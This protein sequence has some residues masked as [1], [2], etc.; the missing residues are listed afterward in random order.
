LNPINT[1][2]NL[3]T[4]IKGAEFFDPVVNLRLDQA[5]G[6]VGV[7]AAAHDASGGY[8]LTAEGSGHPSDKWGWAVSPAFLWNN[9]FGLQGDAI[10]AQGVYSKGAAGY[11]TPTFGPTAVFGSGQ[12]VALGW[13]AEG[14]FNANNSVELTTV[15]S[16]NSAYEHRWNPQWRTS[17]YGG[18]F[19]VEY[20][21]TAK[22]LI[23]TGLARG[24]A[25]TG[26]VTINN[27]N[28]DPNFS[29]S[30][31]GTR[32]LWNP[33]P[34]LD[35]G[36]DLTWWHLNTAFRDQT[37]TLGPIGAKPAGSYTLKDQDAL[38]A[39]FRVQRNFLY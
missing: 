20:N 12:E 11:A 19:G 1:I 7:S 15:W 14:V 18:F 35:V 37:A 10:A 6:F 13:L 26:G 22:S 34:D 16:V 2:N 29:M 32:T 25:G 21:D 31:V 4:D 38:T 27:G 9:P 3:T 8:N 23:C 17:V 28:C 33:V 30:G 36:L 39:I 5:W 24:N